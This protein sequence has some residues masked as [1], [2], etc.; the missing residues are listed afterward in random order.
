M[1]PEKISRSEEIIKREIAG[2]C[3]FTASSKTSVYF[4]AG[5]SEQDSL[6]GVGCYL[7]AKLSES[8]AV[9][10]RPDICWL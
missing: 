3:S 6:C 5:I 2:I 8:V 7:K 9:G 4:R 10:R 1:L